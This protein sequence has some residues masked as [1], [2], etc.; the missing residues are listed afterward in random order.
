V[1][2]RHFLKTTVAGVLS[3]PL[4]DE[5]TGQLSPQAQPPS[6]VEALYALAREFRDLADIVGGYSQLMLAQMAPSD[7]LRRCPQMLLSA[8]DRGHELVRYL[9]AVAGPYPTGQSSDT[10]AT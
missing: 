6:N 3:A 2:R 8:A 1:D 9:R 7:P 4:G 5:L 10:S